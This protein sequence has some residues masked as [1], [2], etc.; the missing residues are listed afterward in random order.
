MPL[1]RVHRARGLSRQ[2]DFRTRELADQPEPPRAP[3]R[4]DHQWRRLRHRLVRFSPG[5][6]PVPRYPARVGRREPSQRVVPN[7]LAAFFR[8]CARRDR[9]RHLARQLPPVPPRQM[10]IHAQR[11]HR[12]LRA[13]APRARDAAAAGAVRLPAGHDGQ[14][15]PVS[16]HGGARP[17][18]RARCRPAADDR[19]RARGHGRT[20]LRRAADHHLG[21]DRRIGHL[22]GALRG[23]R[24][25][26][27]PL[28]RLRGPGARL[29]GADR[30]LQ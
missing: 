24:A 28:L 13:P 23:A 22:G 27:D 3:Q 14:R 17:R 25:G 7:S 18:I 19:R 20:G 9:V 16:S 30:S 10:A 8:A 21:S 29:R 1:A 5:A 6:R 2:P 4:L 11:R 12:G 15:A 26:A